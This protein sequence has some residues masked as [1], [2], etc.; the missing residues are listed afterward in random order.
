MPTTQRTAITAGN[1]EIMA[2]REEQEQIR[3]L[4]T[5]LVQKT[6]QLAGA[7]NSGAPALRVVPLSSV[8]TA[9]T[10][11]LTSAQQ[12]EALLTLSKNMNIYGGDKAIQGNINN[13]TAK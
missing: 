6:S 5:E 10:G 13:I 9:V 2:S 7:I 4:I 11:P 12:V 3:F 8:S 1:L